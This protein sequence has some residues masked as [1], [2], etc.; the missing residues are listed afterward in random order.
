[1]VTNNRKNNLTDNDSRLYICEEIDIPD[2]S[3]TWMAMQCFSQSTSI[4]TKA[5]G[6]SNMTEFIHQ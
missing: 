2:P 1:M 4:Q 3:R 6:N 5:R